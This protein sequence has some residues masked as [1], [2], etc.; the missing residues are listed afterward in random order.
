MKYRPN[1][2][3]I[4]EVMTILSK[5]EKNMKAIIGEVKSSYNRMRKILNR[6]ENYGVIESRKSGRNK[7]YYITAKGEEILNIL[8]G[9]KGL[10]Y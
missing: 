9:L 3:I 10:L 5:G 8:D 4:H 1:S 2:L 6:M 7:L